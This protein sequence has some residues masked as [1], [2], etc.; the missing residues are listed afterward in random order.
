MRTSI[1]LMGAGIVAFQMGGCAATRTHDYTLTRDGIELHYDLTRGSDQS[2]VF[3]HG[4]CCNREYFAPQASY[5]AAK[6]HT[7]LNLDLRGHGASKV[8]EGTSITIADFA[9]DVAAIIAATG[10][11]QPIA[12]GHSMGGLI[13]LSLAAD[14]PSYVGG[15]VMVD[16]GPLVCSDEFAHGADAVVEA[17]KRGDQGPQRDCISDFFLPTDDMAV[18]EKTIADMLSTPLHVA[19]PAWE[20]AFDGRA[21]AARCK[22][23]TLHIGAAVPLNPMAQME[24]LI[25]GVVSGQTVGAGHLLQ[26]LVPTQVN[27]MIEQFARVYVWN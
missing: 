2:Y 14:Y 24:E 9:S 21:M 18:K 19:V 22:V 20:S 10:L 13:V 25:E 27:D 12:V 4:W 1:F 8:P 6:G 15:I 7:V 5:F 3:V 16:P 11:N 23:P 17:M 26:L